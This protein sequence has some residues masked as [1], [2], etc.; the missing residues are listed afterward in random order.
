MA[1]FRMA[2]FNIKDLKNLKFSG[3]L[4]CVVIF[5]IRLSDY[6]SILNSQLNTM[7]LKFY[8]KKIIV[9]NNMV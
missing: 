6:F 2:L 5:N 1:L 4:P 8:D 3:H 9:S 7:C